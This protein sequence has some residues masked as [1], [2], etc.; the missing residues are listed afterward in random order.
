VEE[1]PKTKI[2]KDCKLEL[3][4]SDYYYTNRKKGILKT[5]CK[6][7][8][9]KRVNMSVSKKGKPNCKICGIE[10]TLENTYQRSDGKLSTYCKECDKEKSYIAKGY[11]RDMDKKS[12]R[13]PGNKVWQKTNK[14]HYPDPEWVWQQIELNEG[15]AQFMESINKKYALST[16]GNKGKSNRWKNNKNK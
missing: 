1:K 14:N 13:K 10:K 16:H 8:S 6:K 7:C 12:R 15:A 2:C 11:N 5:C 9:H 4:I 3:P